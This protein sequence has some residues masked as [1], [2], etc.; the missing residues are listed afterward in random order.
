V[1][2][3]R[4]RRPKQLLDDTKETRKYWQLKREALGRILWRTGFGRGCG[5]VVRKIDDDHYFLNNCCYNQALMINVEANSFCPSCIIFGNYCF[6][7]QRECHLS[8]ELICGLRCLGMWLRVTV[9][10]VCDGS[11]P[12]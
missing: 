2:G 10:L 12:K 5:P 11:R 9:L 6:Q 8:L 3:R 7:I 4:G 1:K